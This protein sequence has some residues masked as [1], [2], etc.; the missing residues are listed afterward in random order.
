MQHV[1]SRLVSLFLVVLFSATAGCMASVQVRLLQ[2]AEVSLPAHVKNIAVVD[3]SA[4][5]DAG[6]GFLSVVEGIFTD[7]TILGDRGGAEEAIEQLSLTLSESPRFHATPVRASRKEVGSSLFDDQLSQE[8]VEKLCAD[9]DA[10]ALVSLE[11][12]DSDTDTDHDKTRHE[13]TDSDGNKVVDIVHSVSRT[14][15]VTLTWRVYDATEAI[16]LDELEELTIT[17][18]DRGSASSKSAAWDQ[19][20][21]P[22]ETI[23]AIGKRAGQEYGRRI[24]P[25]YVFENRQ[26]Y[27]DKDDR[28]KEAATEV[29]DDRWE[30]AAGLWR[31]V[32]KDADPELAGRAAYNLALSL[33]LGGLIDEAIEMSNR[34]VDLLDN[35]QARRYR[36]TL[37]ERARD[38]ARL[39]NQMEGA[40]E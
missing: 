25:S 21:D 4:V 13:S 9:T 23:E 17:D 8:I 7:E 19:L 22:E 27:G 32:L 29:R 24:A 26:Y 14:T 1:N 36:Q 18:V 10:Q 40:A 12:F 11:Y 16:L 20:A 38:L 39:D 34:A 30:Q 15:E 37:I 6:E 5:G 35:G 28:L 3:R 31:Q 33:E 2:P